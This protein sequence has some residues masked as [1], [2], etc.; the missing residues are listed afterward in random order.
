LTRDVKAKIRK[1]NGPEQGLGLLYSRLLIHTIE[2]FVIYI[3]GRG[4][5]GNIA[6]D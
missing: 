1:T 6:T 3:Y 4:R 5:G 2:I